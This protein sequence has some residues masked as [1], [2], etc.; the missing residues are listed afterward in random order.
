MGIQV[1]AKADSRMH[2]SRDAVRKLFYTT[3]EV[4]EALGFSESHVRAL[5]AEGVIPSVK[6]GPKSRRVRV[7]DL[8]RW[9]AEQSA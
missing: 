8:E 5:L 7:A 9:A 4:A 1:V 6:V 3:D 2:R